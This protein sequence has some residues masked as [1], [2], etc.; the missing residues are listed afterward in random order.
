MRSLL[1]ARPL[2]GLLGVLI[3]LLLAA[4]G[5]VADD[6]VIDGRRPAQAAPAGSDSSP[7]AEPGSEAPRQAEAAPS[8][9]PAPPPAPAASP[10][11]R[12]PVQLRGVW[13][14][15]FDDT[16][17]TPGSID[18]M[19]DRVAASGANTLIAEVVRRQDAYYTSEV[20]PRTTDPA[21]AD[22]FDPLAHLVAGAR[23]RDLALHAWV[24]LMPAHHPVYDDLPV[25]EGWV[26]AEHGPDAPV[27]QRWVTRL[28]DGTWGDYLDPGHPGVRRHLVAVATEIARRYEVDAVHLDYLRYPGA[29]TGYNPAALRRFR[30]ETGRSGDPA[31]TDPAFSAWRR[32]QTRSLLIAIRRSVAEVAP[33]VGVTAAVIA[34]GEGPG[35]GRPFP[36]TRA[37]ADYHQ[38]W[39]GWVRDGLLDAA[40]PMT[41]FRAEEHGA[42]FRQW[43]RFVRRLGRD[44][45]VILAP[46]VAGYLNPARAGLSQVQAAMEGTDGAVVYSFQQ[47]TATRPWSRLLRLLAG[48]AWN[49]PARAPALR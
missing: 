15:L 17:K 11:P 26:W 46:G 35:E 4:T 45:R 32:E 48:E 37:Y 31:P 27:A 44:S 21:L 7:T 42:W 38:D 29:D 22:D 49:G 36:V 20:L 25:P 28:A 40:M 24:P 2:G 43:T 47:S 9:T 34:Q 41:Y 14:H 3:V 18:A 39:P 1:G 6:P 5:C 33:G 16:L 30:Q 19:L 8:V 10:S 12:P 23:E 13:V